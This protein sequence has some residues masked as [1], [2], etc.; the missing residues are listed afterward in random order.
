MTIKWLLC[1]YYKNIT[2]YYMNIKWILYEYYMFI[3]CI[4]YEY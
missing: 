1:D 3:V 4:L 2:D